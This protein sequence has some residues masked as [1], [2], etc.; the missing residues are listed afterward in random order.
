M[1]NF[2][3]AYVLRWMPLLLRP[4]LHASKPFA[5]APVHDTVVA[6]D[7]EDTISLVFFGDLSAVAGP[8]PARLPPAMR[9]VFARADLVIGNCETPV[10]KV[11]SPSLS[12]RLGLTH[13]AGSDFLDALLAAL[14]TPPERLVLSLANNHVLDCGAGGFAETVAVLQERGI[15]LIGHRRAGASPLTV[16][17]DGGLRIGFAAWTQWLNGDI[18][19]G[20]TNVW[21]APDLEDC[22]W[23]ALKRDNALDLLCGMPHWDHEFRHF[24]Q[25]ATRAQAARLAR[26][27]FDLIVGQHPHVLQPIE[28]HGTTLCAYCLGDLTTTAFPRLTWPNRMFALLEIAMVRAGPSCGAISR[29]RIH[30]WFRARRRGEERYVAVADLDPAMRRKV[31]G[32]L[33]RLFP[34]GDSR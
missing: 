2:P 9:A 13:R 8:P 11:V 28:W 21:F 29:Y 12:Q 19:T 5:Q 32:R 33:A 18:G 4:S 16:I 1:A 10:V 3:L 25:P 7:P 17:E 15:R 14:E 6:A 22:D 23:A 34:A 31:E 27:G 24:P 20:R 26:A 30:V